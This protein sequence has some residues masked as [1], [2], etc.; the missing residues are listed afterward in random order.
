[1][2]SPGPL[3]GFPVYLPLPETFCHRLL[4]A[5]QRFAFPVGYTGV[6]TMWRF[7]PSEWRLI[8]FR[9]AIL[10]LPVAFAVVCAMVFAVP[11]PRIRFAPKFVEGESLRYQIDMRTVS[12]GN[13]TTPIANPEGETKVSQ[14]ISLLVRLD[15]IGA[16]TQGALAAGQSRLRATYEKSRAQSES[17]A[18]NP[19]APSLED[20]YAKVEGGSI[21]FTLMPDG[22]LANITGLEDLFPN[23][24]QTDPILSWISALSTGNSIPGNGIA[25]GQ[26]WSDERALEGWPLTGLSWHTESTYLRD[27]VCPPASAPANASPGERPETKGDRGS[28][29][30][31]L[32][33][34]EIV[35][36][37]S[38]QSDATPEDYR[39]NG[40][41]T[42]G[43]WTGSGESLNTISLATGLLESAT[44]TSTQNMDYQI[45]SASSGSRIHHVG[46][47][48]SQS[49]I[50]LISGPSGSLQ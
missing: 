44:Q 14:T 33:R 3:G 7:L 2:E 12:T 25:L 1:M 21:E 31:L 6:S 24:S 11:S 34:F 47:V 4:P 46:Q 35:H 37:G 36:R 27:D 15:V 30:V 28:C 22:H 48:Q 20:Q 45:T 50:R 29:A 10:M 49:E 19:D 41:R 43:T 32:T 38:P 42:S 40:L 8:S 13:T 39:R 26:K 23:R 16:A 18:L 5:T 9:R 17:D